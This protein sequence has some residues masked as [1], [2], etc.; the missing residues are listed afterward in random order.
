MWLLCHRCQSEWSYHIKH[1]QPSGHTTV[2]DRTR[3]CDSTSHHEQL[4]LLIQFR[5]AFFLCM[6]RKLL[7]DG[8]SLTLWIKPFSLKPL[9]P[10]TVPSLLPAE[11]FL[12]TL[13]IYKRDTCEYCIIIFCHKCWR[14]AATFW[15]CRCGCVSSGYCRKGLYAHEEP[16][17]WSKCHHEHQSN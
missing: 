5:N 12:I 7:V 11:D 17:I 2:M 16:S 14:W 10:Y 3:F 6:N 13:K 8:Y 4:H 15:V 9:I 1:V